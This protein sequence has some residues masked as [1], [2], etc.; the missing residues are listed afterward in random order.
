M[1]SK[2]KIWDYTKSFSHGFDSKIQGVKAYFCFDP[3]IGSLLR[4][5]FD[6]SFFDQKKL[7]VFSGKD[8]TTTWVEDNFLT[9]GLFGNQESYIIT[10]AEDLSADAKSILMQNDLLLDNRYLFLFFD[11]SSETFKEMVK[12]EHI[13]TVEIQ[14]PAFWESDKLLDFV[15]DFLNVR[16]SFP[17]KNNILENIEHSTIFFFNLLTKLFVNFGSS[18]ITIEMLDTIIE[19]NRLD[20]FELAKLFG[21]KKMKEFYKKILDINP[22]YDS[23]RA[24]FYFLQTHM[25]KVADPEFI[26]MKEKKQT[27]YDTQIISQSKLWKGNELDAVLSYLKSLEVKAKT[28]HPFLIQDLRSSYLR[29]LL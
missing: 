12:C 26:Q 9:L 19:K 29:S 10:N 21:F 16:L 14:A 17:A 27:K 18:E 11:K 23:L 3:L 5:R 15:S 1:H 6:K 28:K 7:P 24:L 8:I 25:I 2:W 4:S 20:Q 13:E 22:D